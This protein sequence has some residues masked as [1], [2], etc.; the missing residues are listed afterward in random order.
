MYIETTKVD[1]RN[2]EYIFKTTLTASWLRAATEVPVR[3]V[4]AIASTRHG[5]ATTEVLLSTVALYLHESAACTVILIAGVRRVMEKSS[6]VHT[7]LTY[8]VASG[9]TEKQHFCLFN[10]E[11]VFVKHYVNLL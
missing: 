3:V 5:V 4:V 6:V 8:F 10:V 11:V 2:Q 7:F 1:Y 9:Y